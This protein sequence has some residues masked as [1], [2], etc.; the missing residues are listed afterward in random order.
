[1]LEQVKGLQHLADLLKGY[2]DRSDAPRPLQQRLFKLLIQFERSEWQPNAMVKALRDSG[3]SIEGGQVESSTGES[4]QGVRMIAGV[5][6]EYL[7]RVGYV[8]DPFEQV[9]DADEAARYL[10]V[11][12]AQLD[13]YV[14]RQKRL[15]GRMKGG[16]M[17]FTRQELQQFNQEERR[18]PGRPPKRGEEQ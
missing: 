10:N 13:T 15:R 7:E 6:C 8:E 3:L 9:F 4:I 5:L 16:A 17:L 18:K 1:M 11:S 2:I 14:S 12:R